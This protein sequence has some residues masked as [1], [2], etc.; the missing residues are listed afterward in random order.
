MPPPPRWHRGSG[1]SRLRGARAL[2]A[3]HNSR[4]SSQRCPRAGVRRAS[5]G[6]EQHDRNV[7]LGPGLVL[8]VLGPYAVMVGQTRFL[9]SAVPV[10]ALAGRTLSR[11]W[12]FTSACATRFLYHPGWS[13]APPFDATTT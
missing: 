9:S 12:I 7:A 6:A 4:G 11:T 2:P 1:S 3:G 13:G 8:V 10:R 5:T